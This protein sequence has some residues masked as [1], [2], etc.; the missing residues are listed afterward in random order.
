MIARLALRYLLV[1]AV[2]LALLSAGAYA[3]MSVQYQ[4]ML[5]PA[6]GTPEAA[7]GYRAA[8]T[9]VLETIISF[10][11]PLLAIVGAASWL[12]ARA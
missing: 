5:L 11:I 7:A 2:V 8:M 4:A 12:L 9:R 6:I 10:D 1:F 3:F